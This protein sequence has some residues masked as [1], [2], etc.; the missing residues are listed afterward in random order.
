MRKKGKRP[1]PLLATDH[2]ILLL[3]SGGT[4]PLLCA[5]S[6]WC[7]HLHPNSHVHLH[8]PT[9]CIQFSLTMFCVTWIMLWPLTRVCWSSS[10]PS[11]S[12]YS[13]QTPDQLLL[14]SF[15]IPHQESQPN[16]L[17]AFDRTHW[18]NKGMR[19]DE[20]CGMALGPEE[21]HGNDITVAISTL[22]SLCSANIILLCH[23]QIIS[24]KYTV[25]VPP[26][27]AGT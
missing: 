3:S 13:L 15:L 9:S 1:S 2:R 11:H 21:A 7:H 23:Q 20:A 24:W 16:S 22:L 12:W 27:P 4:L 10:F 25:Q 26:L 14:S 6:T 8:L 19:A 5:F 17:W 18:R